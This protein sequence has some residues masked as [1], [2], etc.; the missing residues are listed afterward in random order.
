MSASALLRASR[1]NAHLS[2]VELAERAATSQPDVSAVESGKRAPTVDTL[3]RLLQ[4][5]GHR[6][7]A[8]PGL[9]PDAVEKAERIAAAVRAGSLDEALRA[10]L[11]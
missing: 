1:L 2:Q 10:F 9:G 5:T 6:L 8:V 11:D 3:E 7:I 4:R